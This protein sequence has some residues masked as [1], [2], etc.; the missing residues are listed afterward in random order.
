MDLFSLNLWFVSARRSMSEKLVSKDFLLTTSFPFYYI[1]LTSRMCGWVIWNIFMDIGIG[2]HVNY[3]SLFCHSKPIL[4]TEMCMN[5][6][7]L[8]VINIQKRTPKVR[9]AVAELLQ[10]TTG[11]DDEGKSGYNLTQRNNSFFSPW[12]LGNRSVEFHVTNH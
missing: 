4:W 8:I 10:W 5:F 3:I 9:A 12:S 6:V 11:H 1:Q 7:C 2:L